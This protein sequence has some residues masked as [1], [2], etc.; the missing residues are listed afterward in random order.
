VA[1]RFNPVSDI[2]R[3]TA[4]LFHIGRCRDLTFRNCIFRC[5]RRFGMSRTVAGQERKPCGTPAMRWTTNFRQA[6]RSS[7]FPAIITS[8]FVCGRWSGTLVAAL[9]TLASWPPA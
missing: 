1:R 3:R 5:L 9:S 6:F 8:A 4:G 7:L 2:G